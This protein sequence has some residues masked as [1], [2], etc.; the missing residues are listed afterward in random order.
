[1]FNVLIGIF[2]LK[3]WLNCILVFILQS[4]LLILFFFLVAKTVL[5]S[6]IHIFSNANGQALLRFTFN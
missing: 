1:M 3:F 2:Y 4:L 6:S 5:S